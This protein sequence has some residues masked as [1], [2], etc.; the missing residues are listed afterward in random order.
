VRRYLLILAAIFAAV[1]GV[2]ALGFFRTPT[3]GLDLQGG[4][5]VILQAR[6]PQGREITQEDLDRSTRSASPSR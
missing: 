2:V 4:L 3:L 1:G 5:E 6:A